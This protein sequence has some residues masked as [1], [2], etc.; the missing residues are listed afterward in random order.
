MSSLET[1]L[2]KTLGTPDNV[3]SGSI[4]DAIGVLVE[5]PGITVLSNHRKE[6]QFHYY[7]SI[8][9]VCADRGWTVR[10]VG[11]FQPDK[12]DGEALY[13]YD[14]KVG[15]V[16]TKDRKEGNHWF[17]DKLDTAAIIRLFSLPDELTPVEVRIKANTMHHKWLI[18]SGE[19]QIEISFDI[20]HSLEGELLLREIEF[21]LKS[22][23]AA[24][25]DEF[26]VIVR[27]IF[28]EDDFPLVTDQKYTLLVAKVYSR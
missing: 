26:M 18:R 12:G 22:G 16:N 10:R 25:L 2:E 5:Y 13:R 15:E 8:N 17:D 3:S 11:W 21:E 27:K 20:F 14:M 1:E 23:R 9:F 24:D 28:P 7:D 19:S 6:R 4:L